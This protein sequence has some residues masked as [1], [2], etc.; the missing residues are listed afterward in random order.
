[1]L[2]FIAACRSVLDDVLTW[3]RGPRPSSVVPVVVVRDPP[4]AR[5]RHR[6]H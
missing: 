3:L 2:D 5:I 1:M 6:W 4:F